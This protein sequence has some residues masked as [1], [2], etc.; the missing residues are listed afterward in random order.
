M[1]SASSLGSAKNEFSAGRGIGAPRS[2]SSAVSRQRHHWL[3]Q[4]PSTGTPRLRNAAPMRFAS[5][6]PSGDSVRWVEQSSILNPAGSPVPGAVAW[7]ISATCPPA[8]KA[9]HDFSASAFAAATACVVTRSAARTIVAAR[10]ISPLP[11]SP[12]APHP[13]QPATD[14][15]LSN[16]VANLD[17]KG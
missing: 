11:A 2:S 1:R 17:G 12:G 4:T 14:L 8:R 9:C 7:R 16:S 6:R 5:R 15:G 3:D 10:I 13:F